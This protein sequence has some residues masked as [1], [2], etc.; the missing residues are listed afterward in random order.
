[1]RSLDI[2]EL[3]DPESLHSLHWRKIKEIP[4]DQQVFHRTNRDLPTSY[5]ASHVSDGAQAHLLTPSYLLLPHIIYRYWSRYYKAHFQYSYLQ[6]QHLRHPFKTWVLILIMPSKTENKAEDQ[7]IFLYV[8]MK[9][10][11]ENGGKVSL[12]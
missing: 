12:Q 11:R 1:M 6:H 9:I 5:L 3:V 8:C 4:E 10:A 2:G 7:V